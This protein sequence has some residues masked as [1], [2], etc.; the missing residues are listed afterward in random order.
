[1][2]GISPATYSF[3]NSAQRVIVV[4]PSESTCTPFWSEIQTFGLRS[5]YRRLSAKCPPVC[6]SWN[7]PKERRHP[8]ALEPRARGASREESG[9]S[10]RSPPLDLECVLGLQAKPLV[11][12]AVPVA[13][14]DERAC[15]RLA[16]PG[17]RPRVGHAP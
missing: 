13:T 8:V 16:A 11:R 17:R 3:R 15:V 2:A 10:E 9:R 1:M 7:C 6:S 5:R 12:T 4:G 14:L